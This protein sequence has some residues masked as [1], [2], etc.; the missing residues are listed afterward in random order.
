MKCASMLGVFLVEKLWKDT[1][2]LII[3]ARVCNRHFFPPLGVGLVTSEGQS[4]VV[5]ALENDDEGLVSCRKRQ[6]R[7]WAWLM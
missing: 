6:E 1:Q 4:R 3:D 7:T 5:V 2:R